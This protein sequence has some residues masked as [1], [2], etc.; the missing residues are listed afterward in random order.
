MEGGRVLIVEKINN[1]VRYQILYSTSVPTLAKPPMPAKCAKAVSL[2][3]ISRSQRQELSYRQ[4]RCEIISK[5]GRKRRGCCNL[6]ALWVASVLRLETPG[7]GTW[8][9]GTRTYLAKLCGLQAET[10][11]LLI[12]MGNSRLTSMEILFFSIE[13]QVELGLQM[14]QQ[15]QSRVAQLLDSGNLVLMD[16]TSTISVATYVWQSF[17]NPCDTLLLDMKMSWNINTR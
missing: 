5:K 11:H 7:T 4:Q 16:N 14:Y 6:Q 17:D 3:H 15:H 1:R 12:S 10:V 13:M 2:R 8:E 9:Y